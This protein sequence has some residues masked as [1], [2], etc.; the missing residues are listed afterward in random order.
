MKV[1][2]KHRTPSQFDVPCP[3][4]GLD[5]AF[6]VKGYGELVL[7]PDVD[8]FDT[9]QVIE[10]GVGIGMLYPQFVCVKCDY[11]GTITIS[12]YKDL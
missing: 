11:M 8:E 12:N 5:H 2:A 7:N 3:K 6:F 4:C 9:F 1:V 10:E